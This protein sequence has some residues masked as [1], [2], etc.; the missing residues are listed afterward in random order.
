MT[1]CRTFSC[2]RKSLA[3]LFT[4][5]PER[6]PLHGSLVQ[7][8]LHTAQS[9]FPCMAVLYNLVYILPRAGSLAWQSC[10]ILFT[11]CPERVPLH[12]SLVQ[13]C[14]INLPFPNHPSVCQSILC[15]QQPWPYCSRQQ[16]C[17]QEDTYA[18]IASSTARSPLQ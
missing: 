5:C 6:V 14:E 9:G 16:D 4:Y 17:K 7:S 15:C 13:S 3:S 11:Y 12:G 10:T 8:C 2:H 18:V 1:K